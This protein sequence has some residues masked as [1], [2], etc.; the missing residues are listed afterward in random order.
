MPEMSSVASMSGDMPMTA[1][2]KED[3]VLDVLDVLAEPEWPP[4]RCHI[5]PPIR[6]LGPPLF[7]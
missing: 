1:E 3:N 4:A 7:S 2:D 5:T 6:E